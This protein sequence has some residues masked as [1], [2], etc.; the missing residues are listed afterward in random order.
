[1]NKDEMIESCLEFAGCNSVDEWLELGLLDSVAPA[2]CSICLSSYGMEPDQE[3]GWCDGCGAH[4][5]VSLPVI[6]GVM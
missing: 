1:M 6:L 2:A 4:T 5:V 3:A